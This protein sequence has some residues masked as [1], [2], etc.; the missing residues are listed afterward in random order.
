MTE[1]RYPAKQ[2]ARCDLQ[3]RTRLYALG[4]IAVE[5]EKPGRKVPLFQFPHGENRELVW[6][7]YVC[8]SECD[9]R[10]SLRRI[11][12]V[13]GLLKSVGLDYKPEDAAWYDY[14]WHEQFAYYDSNG[15][16]G[17]GKTGDSQRSDWSDDP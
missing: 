5:I 4:I 1:G 17:E 7:L 2:R 6:L 16:A 14:I 10:P 13:I 12:K 9:F 11:E 15:S 8:H 3:K